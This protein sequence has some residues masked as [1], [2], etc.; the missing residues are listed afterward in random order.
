M[1]STQDL[2]LFWLTFLS[3][4]A[5]VNLCFRSD[6]PRPSGDS[7]CWQV[8]ERM[9]L[10][11]VDF[12]M[13]GTAH[14][15]VNTVHFHHEHNRQLATQDCTVMSLC[16]PAVP[17]TPKTYST[18]HN[19]KALDQSVGSSAGAVDMSPVPHV[20]RLPPF[21]VVECRDTLIRSGCWLELTKQN[22]IKNS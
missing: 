1:F 11:L 20:E 18:S 17:W 4:N 13:R 2:R 5:A 8:R 10:L 7:G 16:N 3:H 15:L 6:L 12:Q 14:S 9:Y 22:S 19:R 21:R